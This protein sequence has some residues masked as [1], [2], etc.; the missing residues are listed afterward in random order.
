MTREAVNVPV[1]QMRRWF[2]SAMQMSA[3]N[4][5]L[6]IPSWQFAPRTVTRLQI[7]VA[8]GSISWTRF[9]FDVHVFSQDGTARLAEATEWLA[10]AHIPNLVQLR[11][12]LQDQVDAGRGMFVADEPALLGTS[13]SSTRRRIPQ[14]LP[15]ALFGDPAEF[16]R[17]TLVEP[18]APT[19]IEE[20]R[21]AG[22]FRDQ[23]RW[24]SNVVA[25]KLAARYQRVAV[26]TE[27]RSARLHFVIIIHDQRLSELPEAAAEHQVDT[28]IASIV[29]EQ[30]F[31]S[32]WD[33]TRWTKHVMHAPAGFRE[34]LSHVE[35]LCVVQQVIEQDLPPACPDLDTLYQQRLG[36]TYEHAAYTN[37]QFRY[38]IT[39]LAEL[40]AQT[41][42]CVAVACTP[43][44]SHTSTVL[45]ICIADVRLPEL[46]QQDYARARQQ[47]EA[48]VATVLRD[49][50]WVHWGDGQPRPFVFCEYTCSMA[51]IEH[52]AGMPAFHTACRSST[53]QAVAANAD[54]IAG[55]DVG[56]V[57]ANTEPPDAGGL[58]RRQDMQMHFE[59][60]T[61]LC[62]KLGC[63]YQSVAIFATRR[64]Q[65]QLQILIRDE[66]LTRMEP[67]SRATY[68]A[69]RHVLRCLENID[70][71]MRF[72]VIVDQPYLGNSFR[73]TCDRVG[74]RFEELVVV[75]QT[76]SLLDLD[77]ADATQLIELNSATHSMVEQLTATYRSAA[78]CVCR[79]FGHLHWYLMVA[80]PQTVPEVSRDTDVTAQAVRDVTVQLH[81][82]INAC[83]NQGVVIRG[84]DVA[85]LLPQGTNVIEMPAFHEWSRSNPVAIVVGGETPSEA[86]QQL[87]EQLRIETPVSVSPPTSI[88]ANVTVPEAL[89]SA[90]RYTRN[91]AAV[92]ILELLHTYVPSHAEMAVYASRTDATCFNLLVADH[93][94]VIMV[95]PE[96]RTIG[97]RVEAVRSQL[98]ASGYPVGII[99][100]G[101]LWNTDSLLASGTH[102]D[103]VRTMDLLTLWQNQRVVRLWV[104]SESDDH[105]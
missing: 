63:Y 55:I 59:A 29:S 97:D 68:A 85:M 31:T 38:M 47:W 80:D 11:A 26:R 20:G 51:G 64:R 21:G 88:D 105:I 98:I 52:V 37:H 3:L 66:N 90:I 75:E 61:V 9:V 32:I 104:T 87:A 43:V 18:I 77:P 46:A 57:S 13:R 33:D 15:A 42:G 70:E 84:F 81:S 8:Y 100:W 44:N 35:R 93:Q 28:M 16:R 25:V 71:V 45:A 40:L 41:F 56:A 79:S 101:R 74:Q 10:A 65:I 2:F 96:E 4:E 78:V 69:Q 14:V 6:A 30:F 95:S 54:A 86:S 94:S 102:N 34:M 19:A 5:I 23:F 53:F 12:R 83:R 103:F 36:R 92:R 72:N 48:Q 50:R 49:G 82:V 27:R 60:A 73:A 39:D 1:R 89:T 91:D 76:A 22:D 99:N 58:L 17:A 24:A 62:A 7:Q 67:E